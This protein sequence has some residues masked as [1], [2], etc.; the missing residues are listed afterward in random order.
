M[1]NMAHGILEDRKQ[2]LQ[3]RTEAITRY[4]EIYQAAIAQA[5][6][7][8]IEERRILFDELERLYREYNL[9]IWDELRPKMN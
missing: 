8:S 9:A 5:G 2:A 1:S 3:Q 4:C 6:Q 7:L